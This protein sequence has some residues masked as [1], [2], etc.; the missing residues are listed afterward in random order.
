[1]TTGASQLAEALQR[2]KRQPAPA[3]DCQKPD[4]PPDLPLTHGLQLAS[5]EARLGKVEQSINNQN[6][7]LLIGILALIGELATKVLNP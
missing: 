1:M 2:F 4:A 5:I 3:L 6:R 7:I